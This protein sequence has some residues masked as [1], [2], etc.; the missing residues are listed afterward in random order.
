MTFLF[1]DRGTV[2]GELFFVPGLKE[3][4][5]LPSLLGP[6]QRGPVPSFRSQCRTESA[7]SEACSR[8]YLEVGVPVGTRL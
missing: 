5:K 6:V 3:P 8:H 7:V 1:L 4:P 2:F